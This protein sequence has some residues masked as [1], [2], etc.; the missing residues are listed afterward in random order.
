MVRAD[1]SSVVF[2][3]LQ[4]VQEDC[5][6]LSVWTDAGNEKRSNDISKSSDWMTLRNG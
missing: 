6:V 2:V 4:C 1:A 3:E 5:L